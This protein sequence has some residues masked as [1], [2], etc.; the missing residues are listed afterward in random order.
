M[1]RWWWAGS[2][3][4]GA[5]ILPLRRRSDRPTAATSTCT[6]C[7]AVGCSEPC[8]AVLS[9]IDWRCRWAP[10]C[11]AVYCPQ[12]LQGGRADMS[13]RDSETL[14]FHFCSGHA[15]DSSTLLNTHR[16][17]VALEYLPYFAA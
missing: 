14:D 2:G 12:V 1:E 7:S 4:M 9:M 13:L 16:M 6:L 15:R 10:T 8:A 3:G 11:A 5:E 17:Y